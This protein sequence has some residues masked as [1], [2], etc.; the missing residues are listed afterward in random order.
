MS[1]LG[2]VHSHEEEDV[3]AMTVTCPRAATD[4]AADADVRTFAAREVH[5]RIGGGLALVLRRLDLLEHAADIHPDSRQRRLDDVRAALSDALGA[6]RELVCALRGTPA[7]EPA[8]RDLPLEAALRAYLREDAPAG[9]RIRLQVYGQDQ[10]LPRHVADQVFVIV[11][12]ALR[13]ALAHAGARTV[14]A[15][16]TIAPHEVCA[17]VR[18]DGSGFDP[19]AVRRP[20]R[21][22]GL[23]AMEERATALAGTVAICSAPRQGTEVAL[24]IPINERSNGHD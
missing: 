19:A 23:L 5:D 1:G 12:E 20:G 9:T 8:A 4:A 2:T 6:T 15:L 16:V 22:N 3:T 13:N 18:D 21:A 11:R 17:T 14:T 10:P 7:A 24:W